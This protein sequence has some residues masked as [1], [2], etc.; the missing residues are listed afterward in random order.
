MSYEMWVWVVTEEDGTEDVMT[1]VV[2]QLGPSPIPLQ[3]NRQE[4]A[5]VFR[6]L[7]E[8]HGRM[9]EKPVRLAHLVEIDDPSMITIRVPKAR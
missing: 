4:L 7:A 5:E 9:V 3:H 2:P 1:G 6:N 8:G